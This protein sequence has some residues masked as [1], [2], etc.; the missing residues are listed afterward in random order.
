MPQDM[1]LRYNGH[2]SVTFPRELLLLT[3]KKESSLEQ[4]LVG[5]MCSRNKV[6]FIPAYFDKK[7][8]QLFL[9]ESNEVS[10]KHVYSFIKTFCLPSF[11][12]FCQD[13]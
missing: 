12:N 4:D 1:Y 7:C 10:I 3:D 6:H 13:L 11:E 9:F 8:C 5:R 2:I